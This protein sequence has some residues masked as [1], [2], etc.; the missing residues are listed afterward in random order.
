MVCIQVK[1]FIVIALAA[2]VMYYT[3]Q[4]AKCNSA[5]VTSSDVKWGCN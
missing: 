2:A 1:L 3:Y 5:G 4:A